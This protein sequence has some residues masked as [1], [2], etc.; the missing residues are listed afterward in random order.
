MAI[1]FA[2]LGNKL[3]IVKY[4]INECH[5][6]PNSIAKYGRTPLHDACGSGY[7][8]II[9]YF[10]E[11]LHCDPKLPDSNGDLP[12]H[13]ACFGGRLKAVRYLIIKQHCDPNCIGNNESTPLHGA[14]GNGN[15]DL[16]QYLIRE[17]RC[18]PEVLNGM[19]NKPI[20]NACFGG[21]LHVVK[22][23][24]KEHN[25]DPSSIGQWGRTPLHHACDRG[26]IDIV[27][28]LIKEMDCN[29]EVIDNEGRSPLHVA[30][31]CGRT[32]VVQWLL[33]DERVDVERI[34]QYG[35][36]LLYN[37]ESSDSSFELLRLLI[38]LLNSVKDYPIQSFTKVVFTGN[39]GAGKSSLAQVIIKLANRNRSFR[40]VPKLIER[41][42]KPIPV[43]AI[44]YLNMSLSEHELTE[45]KPLT[46]GIDS[47]VLKSKTIG[48]LVLYDL[49]GQSEYYFS[50][51]V[52]METVMRNTPAIF[53]NLVDLSK[54]DEEI[55]QAVHY[56][57]TFIVNAA[58]K[59]TDSS[60]V[61]M[62]GSHADLLS[63]EQLE[64]KTNLVKDLMDRR[65][66]KLKFNC[67]M[68]MD[69][70]K[71]NNYNFFPIL[72][73]CQLTIS[74]N[75]QPVSIYCHMLYSFLQTK[76]DRTAC[77]FYELVSYVSN[78]SIIP[79]DSLSLNDFLEYLGDKGL[80]IYLKN[81]QCQDKSW[82]VIKREVI[83]K[84]VNGELY[85][86]K[87]FRGHHPIA[88]RTGIIRLSSLSELFPQYDLDMLVELMV[89]MEFC[90]P[91]DLSHTTT[92]LCPIESTSFLHATDKDLFF[93]SLLDTE[94]P[95]TLSSDTQLSESELVR[96][97]WCLGCMDYEYQFFTNRFLHVLLRLAYTFPLPS[98][99]YAI[100][101]QLGKLERRCTVW[102]NG[103]SWLNED[104]V[105]T[106]VEIIQQS[107]WVV[108]TMY[109]D[110]EM[111]TPVE[112]SK[113]R[114]AVIRLVLD[115][116]KELV[117]DL[118]TVECLISPSVLQQCMPLDH[119]PETD[120]FAISDVAKSMLTRKPNILDYKYGSTKLPT[121]TAL[122][123]E[124]Y[125]LLSPSSVCELM[126]DSKNNQLVSSVLLDE[127]RERC[128]M[129]Q[130]ESQ[131]H[132]NLRKHLDKISIF[133]GRDP[134]VS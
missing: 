61:I 79:S 20:H 69:C 91:V 14:C 81:N 42:G 127:V 53:I 118:D 56:W 105:C 47:Y 36:S 100:T 9:Q 28:Y 24:I 80:I 21:N 32:Y 115:L 129:P 73:Q 106:V 132:L 119:L 50:Q 96:F 84:D 99:S 8:D 27:K 67:F 7:L 25:C 57:L 58:S 65:I 94:R 130:L 30:C 70:R 103:I 1:H 87:Y 4:L 48:N 34:D 22:Y 74:A 95:Q 112:Y 83:L 45:A 3:S 89:G 102:K 19:D 117:P 92:N 64:I 66:K 121:K 54:S 33:Q 6:N 29:P 23:L 128:Q 78:E 63:R 39:S 104:G 131:S 116:Q 51:S 133:A 111:C 90:N 16:I 18:N 110:K 114:S 17:C 123:S 2:S 86:P 62:V 124:P 31:L 38:P 26:H 113:H 76:I 75:S 55:A 35:H 101:H 71:C 11:E 97:G 10:I 13:V 88:S 125:H 41:D 46:A 108:L 93:P 52:I 68:K 120:L 109:H 37:A 44:E 59:A 40:I 134:L 85:K 122:Y 12:I 77:Q 82:I 72:S 107:R 43:Y 5:C 60:C 98:K 126:D 49:A 15:L